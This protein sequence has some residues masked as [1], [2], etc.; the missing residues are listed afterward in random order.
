ME[1]KTPKISACLIVKNEAKYL[2]QSLDSIAGL[3]SEIVIVDTGSTDDTLAIAKRY[4]D[5][6]IHHPW[7]DHF[8]Q[9]RNA[10]LAQATGDW[11]MILD[12]DEVVPQNTAR[13]VLDYLM[14]PEFQGRP[15]VLNWCLIGPRAQPLLKR[16]LFPN[17][18][19]IQFTF[20]VHETTILPGSGLTSYH[21]PELVI[22][23]IRPGG[24]SEAKQRYYQKL[25]KLNLAE[26]Q[27]VLLLTCLQKHLGLNHLA[28][29]EWQA[30][31]DMLNQCYTGMRKIGISPQDGFYAE[32]LKGLIRAGRP[33][34]FKQTKLF[35]R[36][37]W[38]LFPA[39]PLAH[40]FRIQ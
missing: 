14:L 26:E 35:G 29:E 5:K 4:T 27:D 36:E 39:E 7:S 32:V 25:L 28:L 24:P 33:L 9:A 8:A 20:R 6:I 10:G 11:I 34:N 21:C 15:L 1:Q 30:A 38:R 37:L 3:A 17:R 31:W 19:G 23:H 12:A 22:Q 40:D 2:A 16:G 18:K 13:L